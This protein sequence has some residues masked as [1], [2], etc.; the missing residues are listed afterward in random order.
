MC[1]SGFTEYLESKI[2]GTSGRNKER[3]THTNTHPHA[4]NVW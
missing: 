4:A 1:D 2:G 3:N